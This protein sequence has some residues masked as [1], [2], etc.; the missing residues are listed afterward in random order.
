M[1]KI[2]L[3]TFFLVFIA[4]LGDKTQLSTMILASKT[5]NPIAVFVGGASALIVTSLIGVLAGDFLSKYISDKYIQFGAGIGFIFVG[6]LLLKGGFS[7]Y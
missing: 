5:K 3:S 7:C 2:I 1:W 4:E 6:I